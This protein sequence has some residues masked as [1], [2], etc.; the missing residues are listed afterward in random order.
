[1]SE[2]PC[3]RKTGKPNSLLGRAEARRQIV[4]PEA[5]LYE[6]FR[7]CMHNVINM[8]KGTM[9]PLS[10]SAL[11]SAP[12]EPRTTAQLNHLVSPIPDDI[13]FSNAALQKFAIVSETGID[14]A[15]LTDVI[16]Q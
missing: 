4:S 1:M 14:D 6:P 2:H 5:Y 15:F 16:E 11:P 12:T 8:L 3:Q 9:S 13:A 10:T 7:R